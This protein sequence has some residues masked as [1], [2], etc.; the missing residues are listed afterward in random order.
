MHI[1]LVSDQSE[2]RKGQANEVKK[3]IKECLESN[4]LF[5]GEQTSR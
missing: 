5:D 4:F 3:H 1:N 2:R